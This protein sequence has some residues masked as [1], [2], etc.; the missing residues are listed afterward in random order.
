MPISEIIPFVEAVQSLAQKRL[1]PTSLGSAE[2][3]KLD[4]DIRQRSLFSARTIFEDLLGQYKSD[5]LS[6]LNPTQ[7]ARS[8]RVTPDNP[9]GLTTTGMDPATAR[10]RAKQL[11]QRIGY[12]PDEGTRDTLQD[13]GSD[14]RINL[15]LRTQTEM[16]Q[17]YGRFLKGQDETV[18]DAYPCQELYRAEDRDVPRGFERRGGALVTNYEQSWE[19]RWIAAGGEIYDGRMIAAKDDPVWQNLGDGMGGYEDTLG[20]PYP[21]FAFNSGMDVRAVSRDEAERLGVIERGEAVEPQS[22][23]FEFPPELLTA[24]GRG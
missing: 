1:L 23:S 11:L 2:L 24:D 13:L 8:D 4:A 17:N 12:Q 5:I 18:L 21:P 9:L 3:R 20:N 15:I 7:E 10:L 22:L 14:E 6:I 16:A 19:R